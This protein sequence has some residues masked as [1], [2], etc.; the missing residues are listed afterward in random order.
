M[1]SSRP[2]EASRTCV[3]DSRRET[4]PGQVLGNKPGRNAEPQAPRD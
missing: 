1:E 4:G 2:T 3:C